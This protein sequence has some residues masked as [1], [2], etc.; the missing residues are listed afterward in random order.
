VTSAELFRA[1]LEAL[2]P[3]L[4]ALVSWAA[5]QGS[6]L[7]ST[8][9]DSERARVVLERLNHAAFSVVASLQQSVVDGLKAAAEDGKLTPEEI[10]EI[11]ERALDEVIRHLGGE[12]G[13]AKHAASLGLE[14]EDFEHVIETRIEAE[15]QQNKSTLSVLA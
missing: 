9:I 13:A 11:K 2:A 4:V 14:M 6:R 8:K 15:V 1:A 7:I 12:K 5:W 10:A 3:L